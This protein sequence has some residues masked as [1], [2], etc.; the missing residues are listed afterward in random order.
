MN[1]IDSNAGTL[2]ETG[3]MFAASPSIELK[4]THVDLKQLL[5]RSTILVATIDVQLRNSM[6][7]LLEKYGA[8]VLWA[9]GMEEIKANLTRQH[10]SACFCGFWLVDG[11]YRDILRTVR[12]QRAE[13][14]LVVVCPPACSP[15]HYESLAALKIRAFDFI[16]HPYQQQDLERVLHAVL[17]SV[18]QTEALAPPPSFSSRSFVPAEFRRAT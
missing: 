13:L 2:L 9:R 14:P 6:S 4:Q 3:E 17:P 10:I 11:T 12:R 15:E 7:E 8:S 1:P 5:K 16:R 18:P